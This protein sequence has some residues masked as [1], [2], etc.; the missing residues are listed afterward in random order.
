[1]HTSERTGAFG[2]LSSTWRCLQTA[3]LVTLMACGGDG[4]GGCGD[5]CG[6]AP[7]PGGFPIAQR[8]ENSVQVRVTEEGL[9]FLED[10]I[11]PLVENLIGDLT[12]E[13]PPISERVLSIFTF[14]LCNEPDDNCLAAIEIRDVDL[15]PQ[16]PN[17]LQVD[18]QIV[19]DSRVE[20][21]PAMGVNW[22]GSC[23]VMVDTRGGSRD[24]V[25]IRSTIALT[26]ETRAARA[27]Y[28]RLEVLETTIT[29]GQGVQTSD[30]DFDGGILGVCNAIDLDFITE[31][32]IDLLEDQIDG[33]LQG[34]L[35]DQ[36]CT[37]Q[38][39][40]G[41][42]TGTSPNGA[43]PNAVCEFGD[44]TC[45]PLLLGVDGQGDLG[46]A[47]VGSISPGTHAPGQFL[48]AAGG[49]GEAVNNGLSVFMYGGFLGTNRDFTV[50]PANNP[51]VPAIPPPA[52]PTIPRVATF[53]GNRVPGLT[54]IP[55]VG[56][57]ISESYLDA[58]GYGLFD[59][60]LLC[61]GAG[62]NLSQQ[63]SS[64]LFSLLV[65]SLGQ[66]V[67]PED[68]APISITLRPQTPLAFEVGEGTEEDPLLVANLEDLSI[69][70][71]VWSTERYVRFMTFTSD[72][73]VP[74]NLSV[75]DGELVP[76]I[77]AVNAANSEITNAELLQE[78][79]ASLAGLVES[80][81]SGF[82]A[83]AIS[84][85]G[86]F[87]LP[88]LAGLRLEVPEGGVRGVEESGEEFLGIFANLAIAEPSAFS[89]PADT[90]LVVTNL[91]LDRDAM[92]LET[93][94]Q[95]ALPQLTLA[96]DASGPQGVDYEYSARV[97]GGPWTAWSS[98]SALVLEDEQLLFQA[99]HTVE[100]RARI[101]GDPD[102]VDLSPA[103]AEVL[104]DIIAPDVELETVGDETRVTAR[105]I[106]SSRDQLEARW[107]S[108]DSWSEWVRLSR[109][110]LLVPTD[111]AI[112]EVR[113]EAQNIARASTAI[114]RGRPNPNAGAG[115]DCRVSGAPGSDTGF[116]FGLLIVGLLWIRRRRRRA[117][118]ERAVNGIV[119]LSACLAIAGCDCGDDG[120]TP[121]EMGVDVDGGVE[122]MVMTDDGMPE[123]GPAGPLSPGNLATFLDVAAGAGGTVYASGYSAGVPAESLQ[124]GD[125]V[126]GEY[127]EP[128]GDFLWAIV[129]G[130]PSEPV[131]G[132]PTGWR[133]GV[134][135]AG[136][137]V[138]R[139][140]SLV[141]DGTTVHIAY[142]DSDSHQLK[143]AS[144]TPGSDFDIHVIDDS[145]LN[146]EYASLV[147]T[148]SG[149]AVAYL[150]RTPTEGEGRPT[151]TVRVAMASGVPTDT[152]DWTIM[153]VVTETI[154]CRAAL[155]GGGTMCDESGECLTTPT[156]EVIT[157]SFIEDL[158]VAVGLFAELA[159]TSTGMALVY[160]DRVAGNLMGASFEDGSWGSP[161]LID[162]WDRPLS[163]SDP[164]DV[165]GDSG[166]GASLVIDES[167]V[168]HVSYVD[169]AEERLRYAQISSGTVSLRET[170]DDGSTDGSTRNPDGRHIVGDDSSI[171][172]VDG[173]PRIAY[174]DSTA[175]RVMYA[176]R[177]GQNDWAVEVL[178]DEDSAGYWTNQIVQSGQAMVAHWWR[179]QTP[180]DLANGV[181]LI[182]VE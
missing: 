138:G 67:F 174:Q 32:V 171:A 133:G 179:R 106:V 46:E 9:D 2:L 21:N 31:Q 113:D 89:F 25:G 11:E 153:E 110:G 132:D 81:I 122:M 91:Q 94:R 47:F 65:S 157:D 119:A 63:L 166:I 66:L 125:L 1:M 60:G 182:E 176:R 158:P 109:D 178:D 20:G 72:V 102:S 177:N 130:A 13:V 108:G 181:R 98:D 90:S 40:F 88:E 147:E 137:D 97:N 45:V 5:S 145:D 159:T 78:D 143:F 154:P 85:L 96:V 126:V 33:I 12:F 35:D 121:T 140:T 117:R 56:I 149:L 104:V 111:A 107:T 59:S 39:E 139:W 136:P 76:T 48:L 168:W 124:Y 64:G 156:G 146:G 74:I 167:D 144:G 92:A 28:T 26:E 7:I 73:S 169:G 29:P 105:D 131:F 141:A 129:D 93:W 79:T 180:G 152:L 43:G 51:C 163:V 95:G 135:E 84:D 55:H 87:A 52:R 112:V 69:D 53:R 165:T 8:I 17:R 22:P 118:D 6:V 161:F 75:T 172:V 30:V 57:G 36:L 19:V 115:C 41:C 34:A 162:G 62:T 23:E 77:S 71:Y 100:A 142:S 123:T 24:F 61:I 82:A 38:G 127:D 99:R 160:Y 155:C 54:E 173:Q 37:T 151:S 14:N 80:V 150:A 103:S 128:T 170:V 148:G 44:G 15:T 116:G 175:G 50:T 4:C 86:S 120:P 27:G 134:R 16:A 68:S 83:T 70:F 101:M 42:P 18:L 49:N 10:N 114:I 3:L 58:A 164:L